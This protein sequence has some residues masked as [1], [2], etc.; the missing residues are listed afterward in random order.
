MSHQ[1]AVRIVGSVRK[2]PLPGWVSSVSFVTRQA[3][4][5]VRAFAMN[6]PGV[7]GDVGL[8][9][10][11]WLDQEL[12]RLG[13]VT[14]HRPAARFPCFTPAS[15]DLTTERRIGRD[16]CRRGG[17]RDQRRYAPRSAHARVVNARRERCWRRRWCARAHAGTARRSVSRRGTL[18][19]FAPGLSEGAGHYGAGLTRDLGERGETVPSRS[20]AK[21]PGAAT[22]RQRRPTRR[23]SRWPHGLAAETLTLPRSAVRQEAL[24]V[25]GVSVQWSR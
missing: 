1:A 11:R 16:P 3:S 22:A 17:L 13:G 18:A 6:R 23:D 19:A 2:A 21:L 24:R 7:H 8:A 5:P 12:V 10:R 15:S 20:A 25:V 14:R 4:G 9:P